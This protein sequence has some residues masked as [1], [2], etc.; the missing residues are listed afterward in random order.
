MTSTRCQIFNWTLIPL[1]FVVALFSINFK[2]TG[3]QKYLT[4]QAEVYSLYFMVVLVTLAHIH[5]CI[6]TV[7]QIRNHLNIYCFNIT[8][9]PNN[10]NKDK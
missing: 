3:I 7:R 8:S 1:T 2:E 4:A 10:S 5:Y 6:C 9:Q